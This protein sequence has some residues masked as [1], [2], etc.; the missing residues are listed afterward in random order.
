MPLEVGAKNHQACFPTFR[1]QP[2]NSRDGGALWHPDLPKNEAHHGIQPDRITYV[3]E[4]LL[5]SI[6]GHRPLPQAQ[7]IC[8]QKSANRSFFVNG[9]YT[10][11][12]SEDEKNIHMIRNKERKTYH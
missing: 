5:S 4:A 1:A 10:P 3:L 2:D 11:N 6:L 8:T 12:T 9:N 7:E